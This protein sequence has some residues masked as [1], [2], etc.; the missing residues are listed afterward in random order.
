MWIAVNAFWEGLT[1]EIQA[2][3]IGVVAAVGTGTVGALL[4]VWQ[5]GRQARHAIQQNRH[6]EALKLKL[7]VYEEIV[8]IC[9]DASHAEINL[10]SYVRQFQ[11]D[12][13]LFRQMTQ[14]GLPWQIPKARIAVLIEKNYAYSRK[15]VE[16][17]GFTE[18][19]QIIDPR[20]E[21]VRTATNVAMHDI[22]TAYQAYFNFAVRIMPQEIPG[23]AQQGTL[24]PWRQPDEQTAQ[25]FER[26]GQTLLDALMTLG[27]YIYDFQ[28]EMQNLLLS[29]LFERKLP[30]RKPIDP[31]MIVVEF[32]RHK[33]LA[34]YFD[35]ETAWGR[36]K[37]RIE[38]EV[39]GGSAQQP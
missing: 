29:E 37:A 18:R 33:E 19:W 26:L 32:E 22:D 10:S 11:T 1:P 38:A 13:A 27:C 12:V 23:H 4:V 28:V 7:Q 16:I 31:N 15:S 24:F 8:P 34:E 5:I 39:R 9:R 2:A 21:I 3:V 25:E 14:S 6:N 20:I 30:P 17:I 35:R 36:E